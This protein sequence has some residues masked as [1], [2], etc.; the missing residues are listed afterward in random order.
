MDEKLQLKS[1]VSKTGKAKS[2]NDSI[3]LLAL[4]VQG[5][6]RNTRLKR[7]LKMYGIEGCNSNL[8]CRNGR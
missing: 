1:V 2:Y 8:W 5:H 7:L 3:A 4:V 6:I